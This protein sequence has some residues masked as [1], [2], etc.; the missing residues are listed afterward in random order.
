MEKN[1]A[2]VGS[3]CVY[4]ATGGP[5]GPSFQGKNGLTFRP[6]FR[7]HFDPKKP[8]HG[9][10]VFRAVDLLKQLQPARIFVGVGLIFDGFFCFPALS[11]REMLVGCSMDVVVS[12]LSLMI[13]QCG[14]SLG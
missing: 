7:W 12:S 5:L 11:F 14:F 6:S 3:L 4:P 9:G 2:I 13:F 1:L 10:R 8:R